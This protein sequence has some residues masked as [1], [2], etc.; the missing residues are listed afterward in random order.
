MDIPTH[1]DLAKG[2]SSAPVAIRLDDVRRDSAFGYAAEADSYHHVVLNEDDI[3]GAFAEAKRTGRRVLLRGNG[4]SY[5]DVSLSGE[6]ICLDLRRFCS[7]ESLDRQTGIAVVQAGAS[8]AQIW[9]YCLPEGWWLPVV[10]GTMRTTLAGALSAN[11]HG[12]NNRHTGTFGEHIEWIDFYSPARGLER[13]RP[14]DPD[15]WSIVGGWGQL[16][17]IVR[18]AIRLRR[19]SSGNV[20]VQ[21]VPT[22]TLEAMFAL[23]ESD[24]QSEY[25]V[26]WINPFSHGR[27]VY[28]A[29][30]PV[31]SD[32]PTSLFVE[33]QE[34][35]E[36]LFGRIRKDQ[37]WKFLR[38]F[39]NRTGMRMLSRLK[40]EAAVRSPGTGAKMMPLATYHFPLDYVPDWQRA[41][42]PGALRQFQVG[43]PIENANKAFA[44]FL[45]MS[46][47]EKKEP[48]L[49]VIKRHRPDPAVLPYLGEAYSLALDY[50]RTSRNA[51]RL[52]RLFRE[53]T[54][55]AFDFGGQFYLAKDCFM[56]PA[57]ARR[58]FAPAAIEA[59]LAAKR[60]FDPTDMLTTDLFRRI[61][62]HAN[63]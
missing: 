55:L 59:F 51:D 34:P 19:V 25:Q 30:N 28:S 32:E 44:R 21:N 3:T 18:A 31:L 58:N 15:Y 5:G 40:W 47:E 38:P 9:Q 6:A 14:E 35:S 53:M 11:I 26:A 29:A 13:I 33:Y 52:D 27:G 50:K 45:R 24:R 39:T 23:F 2:N 10:S 49:S 16:G 17:F 1:S 62:L 56:T 48:Y 42:R 61:Q 7:I 37:A 54:D 57:D 12:K 4:R 36:R 60:K 46:Q 8:L 41:Y 43:I 22:P 20:L 63:T